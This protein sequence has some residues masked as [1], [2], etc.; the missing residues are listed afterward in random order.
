MNYLRGERASVS[1]G[2]RSVVGY[3][4]R[5]WDCWENIIRPLLFKALLRCDGK[6]T[7]APPGRNW[8]QKSRNL[9][10]PISCSLP[11]AII[12]KK[13]RDR[14]ADGLGVCRKAWAAEVIAV[15]EL[16]PTYGLRVMLS[17]SGMSKS[18]YCFRTS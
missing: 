13:R 15:R 3:W 1:P 2:R 4:Q 10:T 9:K 11:N 5:R 16:V 6:A 8:R 7:K 17:V 18:T 14:T 12:L